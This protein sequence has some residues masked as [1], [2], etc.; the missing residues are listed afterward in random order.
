MDKTELL[1]NIQ[2]YIDKFKE[3]GI[4]DFQHDLD[5]MNILNPYFGFD[6]VTERMYHNGYGVNSIWMGRGADRLQA[7]AHPYGYGRGVK[8]YSTLNMTDKNLEGVLQLAKTLYAD[9]VK[10]IERTQANPKLETLLHNIEKY[11]GQC[12][13]VAGKQY[14]VS[15]SV[16]RRV[17]D[18]A[19]KYHALVVEEDGWQVGS[20]P[21]RQDKWGKLLYNIQSPLNG[22]YDRDLEFTPDDWKEKIRE[23]LE[24]AAGT[25][26]NPDR[27]NSPV[28]NPHVAKN[29]NGQYFITCEIAGNTQCR[30]YLN[31]NDKLDYIRCKDISKGF[32]LGD[33]R[34]E[35]AEKY[36][37]SEIEMAYQQQSRGLK[38]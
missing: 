36:F 2:S 6:P 38:R 1:K 26:I 35:L 9:R 29:Y 21:L 20:I 7:E 25:R 4:N 17:C 22:S 19:H 30:K 37:K 15:L 27:I 16:G 5:R 24:E 33:L 18:G 32:Y 11:A 3:L 28:R 13:D 8:Q 10:D 14:K 12:M 23:S 31:D 34:Y